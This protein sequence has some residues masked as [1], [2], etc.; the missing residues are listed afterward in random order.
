MAEFVGRSTGKNNK[1]LGY[2]DW[3]DLISVC[4][5]AVLLIRESVLG[6]Q[7]SCY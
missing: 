7:Q 4:E 3:N 1:V 6:R 2:C 5:S